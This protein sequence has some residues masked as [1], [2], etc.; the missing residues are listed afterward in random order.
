VALIKCP[1]CGQTVLSVASVCPKCSYLLLQ[2][3]TPQGEGGEFTACR[4]CGKTIRRDAETCEFCA[5]PHLARRRMRGAAW[6]V[7]GLAV[8][9]L[10]ALGIQR[11]AQRGDGPS[12]STTPVVPAQSPRPAPPL[13]SPVESP[14][15]DS[16]VQDTVP[17]APPI[18]ARPVTAPAPPPSDSVGLPPGAVMRWTLDWANVRE[19]RGTRFPVLGILRPAQGIYVDS[20]R[21]GWW[22]VYLDGRP[23]GYVATDLLTDEPPQAMRSQP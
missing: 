10:G 7:L 18:A 15:G 12:P 23:A 16:T 3:P 5:Y 17:I 14:V 8:V 4:R 1:R 19:G 21:A 11:L 13:P 2:N 20:L 9:A 22:L 6:T